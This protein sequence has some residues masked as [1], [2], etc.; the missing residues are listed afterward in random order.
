MA[1]FGSRM[2]KLLCGS[3]TRR[4]EDHADGAQADPLGLDLGYRAQ[5]TGRLRFMR[6]ANGWRRPILGNRVFMIDAPGVERV[7]ALTH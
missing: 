7:S 4:L 3:E 1:S 5:N 6:E 2:V